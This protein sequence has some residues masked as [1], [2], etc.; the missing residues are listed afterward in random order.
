MSSSATDTQRSR[1]RCR[2]WASRFP[3]GRSSSGGRPSA[4][5][6]RPTSRSA[7]SRPTRSTSRSRALLRACS[8]RSWPS[9]ARPS[10]SARLI[11]EID[12]G[13]ERR[14]SPRNGDRADEHRQ[15]AASNG[16]E[17]DRSGFVSPVVRRMAAE[18]DVDLRQVEGHGVG[19]R[20]RKKDLMAHLEAGPTEEKPS[21][22]L[23]IESPYVPEPAPANGAAGNGG[24]PATLG[25]RREEMSPMRKA[26][27]EHMVRSRHTAA[28]CTTIVEV[29]FSAVAARRAELKPRLQAREGCRSP[30]SRSSRARW[31]RRSRSSRS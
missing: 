25:G 24:E 31:S 22:P 8:R 13:G 30:I 15:Q 23:H 1:S 9:P 3:R 16:A 5:R 29:D 14:P 7:T 2:R 20:I 19:G 12:V 26:I 17:T 27:A 11:A 6:S 18:H 10:L 4:T 28:H 21:K